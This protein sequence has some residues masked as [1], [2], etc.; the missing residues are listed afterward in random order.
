MKK[1]P[2]KGK[3][4]RNKKEIYGKPIREDVE[5]L[6]GELVSAEHDYDRIDINSKGV[7][8]RQNESVANKSSRLKQSEIEFILNQFPKRSRHKWEYIEFIAEGD[9]EYFGKT[10]RFT[11]RKD[12]SSL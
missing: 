12:E 6:V 11:K 4:M 9:A 7:S 1:P 10:Y 5:R 3:P 2:N 8:I